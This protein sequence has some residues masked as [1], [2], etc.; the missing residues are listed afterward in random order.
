M[1]NYHLDAVLHCLKAVQLSGEP[2]EISP[3]YEVNLPP[4]KTL[5]GLVSDFG[6][7]MKQSKSTGR[8]I[9]ERPSLPMRG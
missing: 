3:I 7:A 1:S 8:W 4:N 6:L 2:N 5:A 9:I